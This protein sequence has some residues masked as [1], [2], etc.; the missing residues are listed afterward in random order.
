MVIDS[1][2]VRTIT[3]EK[4]IARIRDWLANMVREAVPRRRAEE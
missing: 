2:K 1:W 3:T 4:N